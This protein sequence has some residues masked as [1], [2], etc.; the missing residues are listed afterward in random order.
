MFSKVETQFLQTSNY[1]ILAPDMFN[2][3][4]G[5]LDLL[6]PANSLKVLTLFR[7]QQSVSRNASKIVRF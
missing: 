4:L 6:N 7:K 3:F 2:L 1:K 5:K